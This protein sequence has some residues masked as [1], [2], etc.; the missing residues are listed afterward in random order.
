MPTNYELILKRGHRILAVEEDGGRLSL[1]LSAQGK[2]GV[3]DNKSVDCIFHWGVCAD[4]ST[5][6]QLPPESFRPPATKP[7]GGSSVQT[8]FTPVS[9][10]VSAVTFALSDDLPFTSVEFVLF[11][12]NERRWDNNNGKN[13]RIELKSGQGVMS[14]SPELPPELPAVNGSIAEL[15]HVFDNGTR[16]YAAVTN[17]SGGYA[18][19]LYTSSTPSPT[20]VMLHWGVSTAMGGG[21][22]APPPEISA[23]EGST[24][25]GT[26]VDSPFGLTEGGYGHLHLE[27]PAEYAPQ[28]FTFV[29]YLPSTGQWLNR[30]GQNFCIPIA[31]QA[32]GRADEVLNEYANEIINAE[33]SGNSWTLMH[34]FNLCYRLCERLAGNTDGFALLVVWLRFSALRQLAWQRN[35][36]TQPRELSHAQDRLTLKLAEIYINTPQVRPFIPL[37]LMTMGP[38]GDGQRIRDEILQIMHR[39]RIKEVSG[40]FLEEWH[41]KLHNNATFDDVVICEAYIA[42][43]RSNGERGRFYE[44]LN[45]GGVTEE[46]LRGFERPIR[47]HPDFVPH[48]KDALIH[49]FESYLKT[50]KAVHSCTDLDRAL[51]SSSHL[52]DNEIKSALHFI[53]QNKDASDM[54]RIKDLFTAATWVRGRLRQMLGTER[55]VHRVREMLLLGLSLAEFIRLL[56]ER[57]ELPDKTALVEFVILA[58]EN[59]TPCNS[60]IDEELRLC[61]EHLRSLPPV[62]AADWVLHV[63]SARERLQRIL[64]ADIEWYYKQFQGKAELLGR[65]FNAA[66]WTINMFT[67]ELLRGQPPFVL[68]MLLRRLNEALR[69]EYNLGTWQ[70]ISP[71][72]ADGKVVVVDTLYQIADK[73]FDCLT[74]VIAGKVTGDEEIPRGVSAVISPDMTDIVSHV[75]VRA[76]NARVL[77]ATCYDSKT[78][79]SLRALSGRYVSLTI[80]SA[81]GV[82]FNETTQPLASDMN[83]SQ[84]ERYVLK[85]PPY[86]FT[87]F[88]LS[89]KDVNRAAAGGKSMNLAALRG[90]VPDWINLP[91]SVVIPFGA[92][93][94]VISLNP[95]MNAKYMRLLKDVTPE[96]LPGLRA[97]IEGLTIP[98]EFMSVLAGAMSEAGVSY[99][100]SDGQR[101]AQ[102]IKKVWASLWNERAYLSRV[103]NFGG[104]PHEGISMAVLIQ[105]IVRADYAFVIHTVNPVTGTKGEI[106]AEVVLG[107]GESLVGNH[108]GRALSFTCKKDSGVPHVAAYPGKSFGLYAD[109]LIFRS[110][111]NVEDLSGFAGAGLYDSIT[112]R[113][114]KSVLLDYSASPLLRDE[115]FR[116]ELLS[117]IKEIGTIAEAA[118][119]CP[120]DIEGAYANGRYYVLQSR[121]QV[122]I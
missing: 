5:K 12:P 22:L 16:L 42:F 51:S 73:T 49:D 11:F 95:E 119:G 25:H 18:L 109:G 110:D 47:T 26:A 35:Y 121:P 52:F 98:E 39:H 60:R 87:S 23:T 81:G 61:A 6:W 13:Y 111:S 28:F 103:K 99:P 102:C 82:A 34:R 43:L 86:E 17:I 96:V 59:L 113:E 1:R 33:M 31:P 40:H 30:G 74:V 106:F 97:L 108:P 91:P 45:S 112:M 115:A 53:G 117:R 64:G 19:D 75:A 36:N 94:K 50:L 29:L 21:W 9:Q 32:G 44:V 56:A 88:A 57:T 77:F 71:F 92:M 105:E 67:E 83:N 85:A 100:A 54:G 70:V 20:N 24:R 122:G 27:F 101:A 72:E 84:G 58:A 10:G 66:P 69:K 93:E 14:A 68:S 8:P 38:G 80:T 46:R 79:E 3:A 37:M 118:F 62:D 65:A 90:N 114:P 63:L 116:N 48:L 107:L 4:K 2:D 120:Q 55:D 7:A 15:S 89:V 78:L 104:N 76:R 41:Q